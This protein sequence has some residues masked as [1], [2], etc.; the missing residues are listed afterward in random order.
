MLDLYTKSGSDNEY[1]SLLVLVPDFGMVVSIL[2]A[3][4]QSGY[5][6]NMAAETALQ[7]LLPVS[8]KL[9]KMRTAAV[10]AGLYRSAKGNSSLAID[11]DGGPGLFIS[12]WIIN[13][14]DFKDLAQEYAAEAG[15][16]GVQS[17]RLYPMGLSS[18]Q[19]RCKASFRA[20]IVSATSQ[21]TPVRRILKPDG[22]QWAA[23]DTP[24]YMGVALDDFLF[25]L[26]DDGVATTV[27]PRAFTDTFSKV[28]DPAK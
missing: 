23:V 10:F 25:D 17:F 21:G 13:G 11:I 26:G 18:C 5:I 7:K 15:N 1:Q 12:Q 19:K 14:V 24:M 2:T 20:L 27:E 4:P 9:S 16:G 3:G 22:N 6:V 28:K 8:D